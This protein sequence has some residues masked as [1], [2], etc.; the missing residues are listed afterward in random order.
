MIYIQTDKFVAG[1]RT[2]YLSMLIAYSIKLAMAILLYIYMFMFNK[3]RDIEQGLARLSEKEVIELGMRDVTEIDN[4]GFR[5]V[6]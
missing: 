4:K 5:Y 3:R 1:Y 6:L 2:A